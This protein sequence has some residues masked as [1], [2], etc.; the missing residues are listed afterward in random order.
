MATNVKN[1]NAMLPI[2]NWVAPTLIAASLGFG[3]G[4]QISLPA[5][6][7]TPE[8]QEYQLPDWHGNVKRSQGGGP[9]ER[10]GG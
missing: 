10:F 7:V 4:T 9:S 2:P 5:M 3:L 6:K 8:I 1:Q